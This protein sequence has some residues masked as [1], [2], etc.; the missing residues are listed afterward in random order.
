MNNF[1]DQLDV[2]RIKLYE[3]TKAMDKEEII[4]SVNSH[5]RKIAREFGIKIASTVPD[6]ALQKSLPGGLGN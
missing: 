3:E 6:S 1:E 5:A 2:I 4:A